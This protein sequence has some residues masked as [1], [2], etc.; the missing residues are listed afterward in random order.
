M[1][2]LY[3]LNN[4][5]E[6]IL[7]ILSAVLINIFL[8]IQ[9]YW[10]VIVTALITIFLEI[11]I[12]IKEYNPIIKLAKSRERKIKEIENNGITNH[13][14]MNDSESKNKR[15][16]EIAKAIDKANEMYLLAETG[17]SYL[18]IPTDRHWKNIKSRLDEGVQFKVL[19]MNPY[20]TNKKVRNNI[21]YRDG[22][23]R[24]LNI[25][26]LISLNEKYENLEIRFTDEAYCSLFF[27]EN[28]MIYDPY[29]LGKISERIENNFIAIEFHRNNRNY[30]ILKSHFDNCWKYSKSFEE[31]IKY[32]KN[33]TYL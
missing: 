18:D 27:T 1:S 23:D 3:R 19:L 10:G 16:I 22:I 12:K 29:H 5:L 21:N 28:Y 17:K 14:F 20:C 32:E 25:E 2:K 30:N 26:G 33:N 6:I 24:K 15:N 8:S 13:Y 11:I 7:F 31:V 9:L 4:V